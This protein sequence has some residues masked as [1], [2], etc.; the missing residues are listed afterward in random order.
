MERKSRGE[1]KQE[2]KSSPVDGVSGRVA[3]LSEVGVEG[4][5]E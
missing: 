5:V 1:A 2:V 4:V 3:E